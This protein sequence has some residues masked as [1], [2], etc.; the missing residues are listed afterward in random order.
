MSSAVRSEENEEIWYHEIFGFHVRTLAN[1]TA[2]GT[3]LISLPSYVLI[4]NPLYIYISISIIS[5][6]VLFADRYEKP[7]GYL[8]YLIFNVR[9]IILNL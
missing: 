7:C 2:L 6:G 4:A 3:I 9:E 1:I 5:G 8:P